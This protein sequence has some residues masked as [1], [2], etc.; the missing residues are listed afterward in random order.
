[1]GGARGFPVTYS[2]QSDLDTTA[3]HVANQQ[4]LIKEADSKIRPDYLTSQ[5]AIEVVMKTRLPCFLLAGLV[6]ACCLIG[7]SRAA[8][9]SI[10]F[11]S[12]WIKVALV[13]VRQP[14]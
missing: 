4:F 3:T 13:K 11:G 12:E 9:F 7:V 1:M 10:D 6:A 8:V 5:L 2:L 14:L